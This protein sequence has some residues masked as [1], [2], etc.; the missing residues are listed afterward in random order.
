MNSSILWVEDDPND[1]ILVGRALGKLQ[2]PMPVHV[3]DG[4]EAV[5]YLSSVVQ[6]RGS[7]KPDVPSLV[8]L[9]LKL[10]RLSGLEVLKW[11]RLQPGLRRLPV[12]IFTSS[13][14]LFDINRA[15]DLGANAYL[16]KPVDF[17]TLLQL[18]QRIQ[19]F[20]LSTN[21]PPEIGPTRGSPTGEKR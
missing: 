16:I 10:P 13:T 14:E 4:E 7:G 18:F 6:D 3:R 20:W 12:L 19:D 2:F 8:L 9:D 1:I 11:V 15:Y 21:R 5:N 17:A